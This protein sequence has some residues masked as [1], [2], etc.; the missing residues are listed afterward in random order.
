MILKTQ[1]LLMKD[2]KLAICIAAFLF[3]VG[4]AGSIGSWAVYYRDSQIITS[5][6]RAKA[7]I[8]KKYSLIAAD[9]DSDYNIVYV[10]SSLNGE[11]IQ[12]TRGISKSLWSEFHK[13]QVIEIAYLAEN[14]KNNFPTLYGGTSL[15]LTLFIFSLSLALGVLGGAILYSFFKTPREVI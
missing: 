4:L 14:P 2:N 13:N 7:S 15:G 1:Y 9:G 10:F 12:S 11:R 3:L 8:L 6:L 5:G